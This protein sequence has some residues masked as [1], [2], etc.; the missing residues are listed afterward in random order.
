MK[1]MRMR[2]S[3]LPSLRFQFATDL[4]V[5]LEEGILAALVVRPTE[6]ARHQLVVC[7]PLKNAS[8]EGRQQERQDW[9]ASSPICC[10]VTKIDV[11]RVRRKVCRKLFWLAPCRFAADIRFV[12]CAAYFI[13]FL[14]SRYTY[15]TESV[16]VT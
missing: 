9:R 3:Q 5:T 12:R 13:N 7:D 10:A 4:H 11:Y 2:Q 1:Q 15:L 14:R 6:A 8:L 16:S